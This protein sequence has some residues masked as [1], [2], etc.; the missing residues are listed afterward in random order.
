MPSSLPAAMS[1][2]IRPVL[3]GPVRPARVLGAFPT[4]VYLA[5]GDDG[6][7]LAVVTVDALRLPC[8]A[9]LARPAPAYD[10]RAVAHNGAVATVGEGTVRLPGLSVHAGR[11]WVPRVP[12]RWA[13]P[14]TL[15]DVET[16]RGLVRALG[17]GDVVA[18][19]GRA[20]DLLGRGDGLT[21]EGDDVLAGLLVA[22]H[23]LPADHAVTGTVRAL[24]AWLLAH[25]R[26]RTTFLSTDLLRHAAR[27][28][29]VPPLLD[30]VDALGGR[31]D[32]AS[33]LTRLRTVGHSSGTAL[34]RGTMTLAQA[35]T[36]GA[37]T[38]DLTRQRLEVAS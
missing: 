37:P 31:G 2:A 1:T 27:G 11:W 20:W 5:A 34:A 23:A 6:P 25:A 10:L 16:D 26:R 28:R 9:V 3:D 36:V 29:G 35:V 13:G 4:A 22:A 14:P 30:V 7:L 24:A 12:R 8:A 19:K 21:P 17:S 15:Y 18:A 38:Y 33:A 32:L